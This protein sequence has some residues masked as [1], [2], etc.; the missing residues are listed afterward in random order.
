MISSEH[1]I[2]AYSY[3]LSGEKRK[4]GVGVSIIL[5]VA[6]SL[7]QHYLSRLSTAY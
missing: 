7:L 2:D 5:P 3:L 6:I 1:R 4:R